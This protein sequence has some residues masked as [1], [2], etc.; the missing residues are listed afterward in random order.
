MEQYVALSKKEIECNITLNEIYGTHALLTQHADTLVNFFNSSALTNRVT[1]A[2]CLM[3]WVRR[4]G[5]Y[6]GQTTSRFPCN[7]T[8]D[9]TKQTSKI[10][11]LLQLQ[12]N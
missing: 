2:F 8:V 12:T 4:L 3:N 6:L 9:G 11:L 7:F 5:R 1:Y 10:P